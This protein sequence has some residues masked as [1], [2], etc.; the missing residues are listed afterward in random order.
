MVE[1]F[2]EP[3]LD[4]EVLGSIP[5]PRAFVL[6]FVRSKKKEWSIKTFDLCCAAVEVL[7]TVVFDEKEEEVNGNL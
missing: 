7:I 6:K 5:A 2:A 3:A 4:K 1:W